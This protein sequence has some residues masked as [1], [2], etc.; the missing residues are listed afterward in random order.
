MGAIAKMGG[1][2]VQDVYQYGRTPRVKGLV[3]MDSPG[4]EPEILTGLAAAGCN[5][6]AFTAG[7]TPGISLCAGRQNNRQ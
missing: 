1:T 4:G 6:I 7:R 5:V 2:V 3:V